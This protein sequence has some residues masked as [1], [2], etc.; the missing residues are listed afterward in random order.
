MNKQNSKMFSLVF[1][2]GITLVLLLVTVFAFLSVH[3]G[4]FA[5]NR[6]VKGTGMNISIDY[7]DTVALY[8]VYK[9]DTVREVGSKSS[10]IEG[11]SIQ[12]NSITNL[13]M[14][15]YDKIFLE[16]NVNNP[17]IFRVE[18]SGTKLE[19]PS[20]TIT[21][22]LERTVHNDATST[23]LCRTRVVDGKNSLYAYISSCVY[24]KSA[25]MSSLKQYLQATPDEDE[26]NLWKKAIEGFDS[27]SNTQRFISVEVDGDN[28]TYTK[29]DKLSFEI[30]YTADDWI[31]D[32]TLNVYILMDYDPTFSNY[33]YADSEL[34]PRDDLTKISL[35]IINDFVMVSAKHSKG[36]NQ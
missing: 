6:T 5:E 3:Y 8:Y 14:L 28:R 36:G 32:D 34:N 25:S 10:K 13:Q 11:G 20:G 35:D 27:V 21:V 30:P 31:D 33:A 18:V 23:N 4:W 7:D 12:L 1:N 22:Y 2:F 29:V 15:S 19:K 24:F 16:R 9:Y 26:H 17:V